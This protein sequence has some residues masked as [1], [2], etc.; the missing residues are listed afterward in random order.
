MYYI[1]E[2]HNNVYDIQTITQ[3]FFPNEGFIRA[4]QFDM[5]G[6]TAVS[7]LTPAECRGA[8]Y[9][10]G[11]MMR[12][13]V[14]P[15]PENENNHRM[16]HEHNHLQAE[17]LITH[18]PVTDRITGS[19]EIRRRLMIA[20]FLACR[21]YTGQN[22]PWGALTGIRPSKMARMLLE[23]GYTRTKIIDA[24]ERNYLV[25]KDKISLA[26]D[27]AAVENEVL[28]K[29]RKDAF[30][31]YV[32]IPFCPSRC[33]YCSFAS[34]P[35]GE[36]SGMADTYMDALERELRAVRSLTRRQKVSAVYVGG[37]T[38]T[39]LNEKQLDRLLALIK[40]L[41]GNSEEFDVEAGRPETLN[42]NKMRI[43]KN[44]GVSRISLNPQSLND[45]TLIRIGRNHTVND[46]YKSF[47]L[48][49]DQGFDN[50]N[51]DIILGLPGE[52]QT[53]CAH[54]MNKLLELKPENL[55][56]HILT[57][58]RAS[59]LREALER[60]PLPCVSALGEMIEISQRRCRESGL[61]PYYM[62]RQKNM[63]GN[64]ENVG[65]CQPGKQSLYNILIME[66][67]QTIWAAGAGA[68]SKLVFGD[69]L[70]RVFNVKSLRD[71]ITRIDEMI[72]RKEVWQNAVSDTAGY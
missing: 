64:F 68:I 59:L 6:L 35:A 17:G 53:H 12:E 23:K 36:D 61:I 9:K 7:T 19:Q 50:I 20:L 71:Y 65:Y 45:E 66:E 34:Y 15:L 40:S 44:Y 27:V 49:R 33:L 60:Y 11:S 43:L 39:S 5:Q 42:L 10:D 16:R 46:F 38:P 54:T 4:E 57:I 58:K 21:A 62:Y 47:A 3:I 32:G 30:S 8:L 31:L 25:R 2:G 13:S 63:L 48:A 24:I 41:F 26:L 37:G 52:A 67:T 14:Y 69:K 72:K 1:L 28:K 18:T 56:V 51:T 55:T 70:T 29:D 22:P